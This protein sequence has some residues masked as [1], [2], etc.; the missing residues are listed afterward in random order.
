MGTPPKNIW[1]SPRAAQ[2]K[3]MALMVEMTNTIVASADSQE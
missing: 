3:G 1:R 2:S